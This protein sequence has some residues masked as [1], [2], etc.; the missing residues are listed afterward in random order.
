MSDSRFPFKIIGLHVLRECDERFRKVLKPDTTYF[1]CNDYEDDGKGGVK[2]KT[3]CQELSP[4][5]FSLHEN[6]QGPLVNISCIV[7]HNGDGKSSLIELLI[8]TINNFAYFSGFRSDHP[9][10]KFIPGVYSKLYF[11]ANNNICCINCNG[12]SVEFKAEEK[13]LAYKYS[14]SHRTEGERIRKKEI[15]NYAN[16]LFHTFVSNYSLYAYNS[17]EYK[18][19]SLSIDES[20]SWISALFN[21]NYAYQT[22]IIIAPQ[23][24]QGAININVEYFLSAQRLSELFLDCRQ[25][26]FKI[27]NTEQVEGF[28]YKM[29]K[30]SK[31]WTKTIKEYLLK[32]TLGAREIIHF[33]VDFSKNKFSLDFT[34]EN[35]LISNYE[36][37]GS[38]D[39]GF[40]DSNLLDLARNLINKEVKENVTSTN[41]DFG[42][43]LKKIKAHV[44]KKQVQSLDPDSNIQDMIAQGGDELTFLQFQRI[45]LV[46]EIMAR[47][48]KELRIN[49]NEIFPLTFT[50]DNPINHAL[51][52]LTYKTIKVIES[53]P[54]YFAVGISDFEIPQ[55]FFHNE[56]HENNINNWFDVLDD[57]IKINQSH[58]TL[59]IRQTLYFIENLNSLPLLKQTQ[60]NF[61]NVKIN[62]SSYGYDYY[63]TCEQYYDSIK[64]VRDVANAIPPPI[65]EKDYLISHKGKSLYLL[66]GMSSGERQ[67]LNSASSIVYYLKNIAHSYST[68]IKLAYRNVNVVLEEVELYFHPEYQRRFVKYLLEQIENA[69]L[70]AKMS[71]NLIFVTHSPFIL[72]D[73][74]RQNVLFL[75]DG[76]PDRSMQED[77]FGANIHTLLQNGFFLNSVPIGA[78][79]KE[80]ISQMF[81]LLNQS[82]DISE[83]SLNRLEKEIPLVSEPLLRNQLMHLFTTRKKF[84]CDDFK[85]TIAALEKRIQI[86][87][88][89]LHDK[90]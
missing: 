42:Q 77:T 69:H 39:R 31:L 15:L 41:T 68:P 78:F 54:D 13:E 65:F 3:N 80:K 4:A 71:I 20:E 64:Q 51:W 62:I 46:Y 49:N 18:S 22:P 16:N 23:R 82:S 21:T 48:I 35:V 58:L 14:K 53:Y 63:L 10:L 44:Q 72:S 11:L 73:I 75:K 50:T 66:S 32:K 70:P 9:D 27:S 29:E 17:C 33:N 56:V 1:F 12:K 90:N 67:L 34:N 45:Y 47:W 43:Y 38:F 81:A 36:F 86:L 89:R 61:N 55:H 85:E 40:F 25:G 83:D 59:K 8:R 79:A 19:E 28:A 6:V 87:E 2:K 7:G 37:W 52:Y 24:K 76:S 26:K 30:Q 84:K 57:D 5:F 74:P 88:E 60:D